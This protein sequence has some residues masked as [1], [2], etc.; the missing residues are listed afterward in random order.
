MMGGDREDE[1]A[2]E[3]ARKVRLAAEGLSWRDME[4]L[5]TI[6]EDATTTL[7]LSEVISRNSCS[8][9]EAQAREAVHRCVQNGDLCWL[10]VESESRIRN[11]LLNAGFRLGQYLF[12][13]SH[14]KPS[15]YE[16]PY[17]YPYL[18]L[19]PSGYG[20]YTRCLLHDPKV[21]SM[22]EF[23]RHVT[24][25]FGRGTDVSAWLDAVNEDATDRPIAE[26]ITSSPT[27]LN[28]LGYGSVDVL[29]TQSL[30][31]PLAE[32]NLHTLPRR[33]TWTLAA[34]DEWFKDQLVWTVGLSAKGEVSVSD[35]RQ[36]YVAG[37]WE[38]DYPM[39]PDD[40]SFEDAVRL[41]LLRIGS[42]GDL[43]L[44]E[45]GRLRM[46]DLAEELHE[47]LLSAAVRLDVAMPWT[48]VATDKKQ[49][50]CDHLTREEPIYRKQFASAV[51]PTGRWCNY[52]YEQFDSGYEQTYIVGEKTAAT[53]LHRM[54]D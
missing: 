19:T 10:D 28:E 36:S 4:V 30:K 52:W 42:G 18:S 20:K 21:G 22:M 33:V 9:S 6:Q 51:V 34:Q 13:S 2:K 5:Q 29:M 11:E 41:D 23:D 46:R 47:P 50:R 24:R 17:S 44:G 39:D 35:L 16:R 27:P 43:Q 15:S 48:V 32:G 45:S 25:V 12:A 7:T 53:F 49:V 37:F 38:C 26:I 31:V 54:T 14:E 8:L 1:I 3:A 40:T